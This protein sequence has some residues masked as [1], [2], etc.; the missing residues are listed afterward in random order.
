MP[1]VYN[2]FTFT[3]LY[4]QLDYISKPLLYDKLS[5]FNNT[6]NGDIMSDVSP[7]NN[8]SIFKSINNFILFLMGLF[9]LHMFFFSKFNNW[10]YSE[11]CK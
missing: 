2:L 9:I 5:I 11:C 3:L 1:K 4:Y 8:D 7:V 6:T 10:K